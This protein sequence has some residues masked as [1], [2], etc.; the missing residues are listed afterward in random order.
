[1]ASGSNSTTQKVMVAGHKRRITSQPMLQLVVCELTQVLR[2][3]TAT[4]TLRRES[5]LIVAPTNAAGQNPCPVC[6]PECGPTG[7]ELGCPVCGGNG[8]IPQGERLKALQRRRQ[9]FMWLV[10]TLYIAAIV[11]ANGL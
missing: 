3:A 10:I 11:V 5:T 8:W 1:M 2:L 4:T 6:N 9:Y 7:A